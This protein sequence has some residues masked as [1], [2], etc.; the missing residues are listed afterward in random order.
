MIDEP[1]FK[2]MTPQIDE[3][4]APQKSDWVVGEVGQVG[5]TTP[6]STSQVDNNIV[7]KLL[8]GNGDQA[9]TP[10]DFDTSF[11]DYG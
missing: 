6:A 10:Y 4:Q 8:Q 5:A 3:W 11:G 2:T 1:L 9:E 7:Q